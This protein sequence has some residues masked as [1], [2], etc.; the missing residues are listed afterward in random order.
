MTARR[1]AAAAA[2][3]LSLN[4]FS[5]QTSR[6]PRNDAGPGPRR[7]KPTALF[8]QALN[9]IPQL[10]RLG[11][12]LAKAPITEVDCRASVLRRGERHAVARQVIVATH[13]SDAKRKFLE[14]RLAARFLVQRRHFR[15]PAA[16]L[17]AGMLASHPIDPH[18]QYLRSEGSTRGQASG[19]YPKVFHPRANR[20]HAA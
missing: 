4:P 10:L 17:R 8:P 18:A 13:L 1:S 12:L 16:R 14:H 19:C 9:S 2:K 5:I 3:S 20:G 7:S 15:G 11:F 6:R